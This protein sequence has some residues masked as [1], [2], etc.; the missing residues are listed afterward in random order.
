MWSWR[1]LRFGNPVSA[2]W[3][4]R[5]SISS[6]ARLR[7]V[8]SMHVPS[9]TGSRPGSSMIAQLSRVHI[10][11]AAAAPG[12]AL[13]VHERPLLE[14]PPDPQLAV[15]VFRVE[16]LGRRVEDVRDRLVPE[17]AREALVALEHPPVERGPEEP[18]RIALVEAPE[19]PLGGPETPPRRGSRA[20]ASRKLQTRPTGWPSRRWGSEYRSKILP[21]RKRRMSKLSASGC[22][23]SSRTFAR[24]SCGLASWPRTCERTRWSSRDARTSSG[25]AH[26]S[27]KRR[28]YE[29]TRLVEVDDEDAVRGG[30]ERGLEEG[31]RAPERRVGMLARER[32]GDVLRGVREEAGLALAEPRRAAVAL[33]DERPEDPSARLQRHAD[34]VERGRADLLHFA[35][36]DELGEELRGGE[37]RPP[38]SDHVLRQAAAERLGGGRRVELVDEVRKAQELLVGV[39]ERDVEVAGVDEVSD[40]AV[41]GGVELVRGRGPRPRP[42]PRAPGSP[43]GR[44]RVCARERSRGPG[45]KGEEAARSPRSSPPP[46]GSSRSS[47]RREAA[48]WPG[49]ARRR[50]TGRR[51]PRRTR[52]RRPPR[53][54]GPRREARRRPR[55][56]S[57]CRRTIG[58]RRP[59]ERRAGD[60]RRLPRA[61]GRP[62][63]AA[64][65]PRSGARA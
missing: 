59:A 12:E 20:V 32:G 8:M 49:P 52:A 5:C 18:G 46:G 9:I 28:L 43:G 29:T 40:E 37:E 42:P 48:A 56:S 47:R 15:L 16:L 64:R 17:H 1:H 53:A 3:Y 31:Q 39:P 41:D 25:I 61:T 14:E 21:S 27:A 4:A 50:R 26:S 35:P 60:R 19:A 6:S 22:S 2:S 13:P 10:G 55:A 36:V 63:R 33:D 45:R 11:F 23:Y 44:R 57:S 7:S 30:F 58:G 24:N 34:P 51:V 65:R 54:A 38:G 62:G